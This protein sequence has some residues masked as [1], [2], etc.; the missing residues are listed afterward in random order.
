MDKVSDGLKVAIPKNS[1]Y[2]K[3]GDR[4]TLLNLKRGLSVLVSN[5]L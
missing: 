3:I 4:Y 1:K 5:S 2:V